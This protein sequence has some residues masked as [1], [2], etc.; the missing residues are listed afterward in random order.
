[1]CVSMPSGGSRLSITKCPGAVRIVSAG[2]ELA[3]VS[4]LEIE[5][6][7]K[8]L[9]SG[10][11]CAPHPYLREG[12]IVRVR[13]GPLKD[14]EGILVKVKNQAR[15]VLSVTLLSRSV[16]AEVSHA[17]VEVVR[18]SGGPGSLVA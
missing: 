14:L 13:R 3:A 16:A 2:R 7:R 4:E 10:K 5:S 15:L 8:M 12:A 1:M 11:A 9:L 17:D 6:I 18:I